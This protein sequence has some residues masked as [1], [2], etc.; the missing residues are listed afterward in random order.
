M[1][2]VQNQKL[3]PTGLTA[4]SGP[5]DCELVYKTPENDIL[6]DAAPEVDNVTD[7]TES[8]RERDANDFTVP[9]DP[10][11]MGLKEGKQ[12]EM[13][14]GRHPNEREVRGM[15]AGFKSLNFAKCRRETSSTRLD[16]AGAGTL[17]AGYA[18]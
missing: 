4:D 10:E 5:S 11:N 18:F 8:F 17:T 16:T 12:Y 6:G 15:K 1:G 3:S 14:V 2:R 7:F 13:V 9:P